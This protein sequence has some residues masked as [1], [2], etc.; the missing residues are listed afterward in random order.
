MKQHSVFSDT[1]EYLRG[2]TCQVTFRQLKIE[3][4]MRLYQYLADLAYGRF[5]ILKKYISLQAHQWFNF[6]LSKRHLARYPSKVFNLI[7]AYCKK[8]IFHNSLSVTVETSS[9]L[10]CGSMTL[11]LIKSTKSFSPSVT[12]FLL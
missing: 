8:S 12:N 9:A 10:G 11:I 7:G 1:I 6:Q 5:H 2:I 4:I 3:R